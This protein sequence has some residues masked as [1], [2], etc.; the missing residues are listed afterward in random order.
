V[1]RVGKDSRFTSA[2]D[3]AEA[4]AA[5]STYFG[6]AMSNANLSSVLVIKTNRFSFA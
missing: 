2:K 6:S 4:T 5:I 3:T 1:E